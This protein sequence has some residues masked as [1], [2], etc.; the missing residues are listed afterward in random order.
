VP[1]N[2]GVRIGRAAADIGPELSQLSPD[3]LG[4][5][6]SACSSANR[7]I[8]VIDTDAFVS[9]LDAAY[10]GSARGRSV[11]AGLRACYF[12]LQCVVNSGKGDARAQASAYQCALRNVDV[13]LATER[14][15]QHLVSALLLLCIYLQFGGGRERERIDD[16][17]NFSSL[18]HGLSAFIESGLSPA[19]GFSASLFTKKMATLRSTVDLSWP[20]LQCPIGTQPSA[21]LVDIMSF[22][23]LEAMGFVVVAPEHVVSVWGVGG[24]FNAPP[25]GLF[26]ISARPPPTP[27]PTPSPLVLLSA[28][29]LYAAGRGG[30]LACQ[31]QPPPPSCDASPAARARNEGPAVA[32]RG[33]NGSCECAHEDL[34]RRL[35]W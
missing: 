11:P 12:A 1:S 33:T 20:A 19:V 15:T 23:G 35:L 5:V 27:S 30:G 13:A 2:P 34:E 26:I 32:A 7:I 3:E 28:R 31:A 22:I 6:L 25:P 10:F 14:P 18:A 29:V 17:C 8:P 16:A 21:R 4:M 24:A 9:S